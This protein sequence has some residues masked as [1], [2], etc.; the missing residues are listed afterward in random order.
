MEGFHA[1]S[2]GAG[3]GCGGGG[4]AV[5][6]VIFRSGPGE[7]RVEP[8][9][10][11]DFRETATAATVLVAEE[12]GGEVVGV[13]AMRP[14][15]S[16]GLAIAAPGEAELGRLAVAPL[17]RGVGVGRELAERSLG[18]A[19][20]GGAERVALWSR[21]YQVQAHRLY[22]TLGFRRAPGRDDSD[23]DGRRLVFTFAFEFGDEPS[24]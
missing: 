22:E 7:G 20:D 18:L 6:R 9:S 17:A 10:E 1:N 3:G 4:D 14:P 2:R 11:A 8:Y 13:A 15:G 23:A 12:D 16:S 5:D 19:R 21:P 24:R